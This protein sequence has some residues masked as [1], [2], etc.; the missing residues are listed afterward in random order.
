[1]LSDSPTQTYNK[2]NHNLDL[3]RVFAM[4]A[5]V[6]IHAAA[7]FIL[8]DKL[9]DI[10]F[11]TALTYDAFS[12]FCVPMFVMLS[13]AVMFSLNTDI[14]ETPLQFYARKI[15]RFLPPIAFWFIFYWFFSG[16]MSSVW[17]S[18]SIVEAGQNVWNILTNGIPYYHLWYLYMLP[19]LFFLGPLLRHLKRKVTPRQ[20]MWLG[21]GFL[22][23]GILH[24][25]KRIITGQGLP[26]FLEPVD[27]IGYLILGDVLLNKRVSKAW[28]FVG[29]IAGSFVLATA[30]YTFSLF[31][32]GRFPFSSFLS[33]LIVLPTVSLFALAQQ[34]LSV[35]KNKLVYELAITS[36]GV[37][38]V[39]AAIVDTIMK[40]TNFSLTSFVVVDIA[41]YTL[42]TIAISYA[43]VKILMSVKWLRWMV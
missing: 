32:P 39:H 15:K 29:Y 16:R 20:W 27:F 35:A 43:I 41:L 14:D 34:K 40:M 13:G 30:L 37:Y 31:N 18:N 1:M 5:V 7:P 25:A 10:N 21:I 19:G 22:L 28:S 4:T 6:V 42:A 11:A 26:F 24:N 9:P 3:L 8:G 23:F 38:L 2:R 12:R 33:P 17:Q 36:F